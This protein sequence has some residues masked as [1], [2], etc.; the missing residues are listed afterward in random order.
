M[1]IIPSLTIKYNFSLLKPCRSVSH[2]VWSASNDIMMTSY[3]QVH[4]DWIFV[5]NMLWWIY[6]AF[7]MHGTLSNWHLLHISTFLENLKLFIDSFSP[8]IEEIE[9][10]G[11][12]CFCPACHSVL[13]SETLTLLITFKQW[14]LELWYFTW[15]YSLW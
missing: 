2:C 15:I 1:F 11:A 5:Y 9:D 12:Y 6:Q 14:V 3:W 7:T 4:R 13:L 8:L 10:R